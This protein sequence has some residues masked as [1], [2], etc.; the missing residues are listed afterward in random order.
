MTDGA[1]NWVI[2]IMKAQLV[3]C[4]FGLHEVLGLF[5]STCLQ[6]AVKIQGFFDPTNW[7]VV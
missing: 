1:L 7:G 4:L 6:C 5:P 3:E 2:M